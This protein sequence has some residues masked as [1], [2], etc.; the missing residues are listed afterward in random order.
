MR[1]IRARLIG[2]F[3]GAIAALGP[4]VA[5]NACNLDIEG[6]TSTV[7]RGKNGSGYDVY[8]PQ[9]TSHQ[10]NFQVH[11][12]GN[13]QFFVTIVPV[14]APGGGYGQ[15][16]GPG[17]SLQYGAFKDAA[18]TQPLKPLNTATV[19]DV[20]TGNN[21]NGNHMYNYHF[22]LVMPP[23]Q[24]VVP[25]NYVDQLEFIAYEGTLSHNKLRDRRQTQVTAQVAAQAEISFSQGSF[26]PANGSVAVS[27]DTLTSGERQTIELLARSNAGYRI[28]FQ[29][30]NG[31]LKRVE[32]TIDFR[33]PYRM[34]ANGGFVPLLPG[35]TVTP[36]TVVQPS[37]PTG[38]HHLLEFEVGDLGIAPGGTYRDVINLTITGLR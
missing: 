29:S 35:I 4:A 22:S 21:P 33:V 7:I 20:L 30:A 19:N 5:V 9:Q 23:Q 27:F 12:R 28:S 38:D 32:G 17:G 34:T 3:A 1:P 15:L 6:I 2:V 11:A 36:I 26:D 8:D 13:C 31:A 18:G 25:G 37:P 14:S 16:R 24:V 10:V